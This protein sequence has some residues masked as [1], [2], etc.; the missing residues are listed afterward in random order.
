MRKA[1]PVVEVLLRVLAGFAVALA[2]TPAGV[3]GAFL[4]L[5]V[6]VLVFGAPG[7][8]V[9]AT[10]LLYN[11]TA[12]PSGALGLRRV[13]RLDR[14]LI[15]PLATGA[16][17]GVVAGVVLRSTVLAGQA[18]FAAVAA[19]VLVVL[20]AR[21]LAGIGAAAP[22]GSDPPVV[23][24][25]RLVVLGAVAAAIGGVYGI[26]GAALV[27]PWLVA[28]ER[29]PIASTA[30]AGLVTTLITSVVGLAAFVVLGQLDIG[31]AAG[32]EWANGLALGVGGAAGAYLGARLQPRLPVA[33]LRGVVGVAA[34]VA[35]IRLA[36][37]AL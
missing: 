15:V 20:G 17:P 13:G 32:P 36:L 33:L 24:R 31:S 22:D 30:G 5:P 21:L 11:V 8:S 10:N 29:L 1:V 4:L 35:G 2:C 12:T 7:P 14:R 26:G 37:E 18:V 23:A 28:V 27:V 34:L 19:V 9:S 25:R 6:Q 3:S 16:V